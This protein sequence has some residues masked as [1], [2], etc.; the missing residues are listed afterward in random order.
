MHLLKEKR[1]LCIRK[2][3]SVDLFVIYLRCDA[4]NYTAHEARCDRLG[5][6][7]FMQNA[8]DML[9]LKPFGKEKPDSIR[10]CV[11]DSM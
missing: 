3:E 1:N 10:Y 11:V 4:M 9:N 8:Y 2:Y 5:N 7:T 6:T